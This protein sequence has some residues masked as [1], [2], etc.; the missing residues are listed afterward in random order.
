MHGRD[1]LEQSRQAA[2]RTCPPLRSERIA[3]RPSSSLAL[4][5]CQT[6][7][8]DEPEHACQRVV[9]NGAQ[10]SERRRCGFGLAQSCCIIALRK[11]RRSVRLGRVT[12]ATRILQCPE[13]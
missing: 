5:Q 2:I 1:F 9:T 12:A 6:N 11:Q 10:L 13:D 4:A 3:E 7:A 8:G